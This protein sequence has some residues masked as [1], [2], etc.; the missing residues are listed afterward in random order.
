[1]VIVRASLALGLLLGLEQSLLA[2]TA[3]VD[4]QYRQDHGTRPFV[5]VLMNGK[6]FL[7]M[8]HSGAG[9]Y[10]MTTHG[11]AITIGI[12]KLQQ[13][14]NYGI[15]SAGH[16]SPLGR[17]KGKLG[18]LIVGGVEEKDVPILLFEIP[19]DP[20]TDGMLGLGWLTANHV[21]LDFD[22][23]RLGLPASPADTMLEDRAFLAR[24][25]IAHKM[26]RDPRNGYYVNGIV[27]GTHVRIG[28]NTVMNDVLEA[29]FASRAKI[30]LGPIVDDAGGPKGTVVPVRI[31]KYQLSVQIDGQIT[32]PSQPLSWDT[33]AYS[34]DAPG[35]ASEDL[36]LGLDFML[37]NQA[38]I[39]F[40][41]ETIYQRAAG[42][43]NKQLS[44]RA[45]II[46]PTRRWGR[47]RGH[48]GLPPRHRPPL[49]TGLPP[50]VQGGGLPAPARSHGRHH[51][52][53]ARGSRASFRGGYLRQSARPTGRVH[54]R[55]RG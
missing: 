14:G 35:S 24:G 16:V 8:V 41:S 19:Q 48:Q 17:S 42:R 22:L 45:T 29:S 51:W 1:M 7:M 44:L 2:A 52:M 15:T 25:Y 36:K 23:G 18:S 3:Y 33:A 50:Q 6:P 28:V 49:G 55:V 31:T 39:D 9:F 46:W 30:P 43:Q 53:G 27:N 38:I 10:I 54:G 26:V 21:I 4:L 13:I 40:G 32:S 20:P 34:S 47:S 12:D 5:P 37:A 11:N